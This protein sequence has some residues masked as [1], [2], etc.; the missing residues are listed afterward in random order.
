VAKDFQIGTLA[1]ARE[2]AAA[3]HLADGHRSL[4]ASNAPALQCIRSARCGAVLLGAIRRNDAR[5][6]AGELLVSARSFSDI[7]IASQA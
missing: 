4:G 7:P 3:A 5:L 6:A 1:A 2:Q